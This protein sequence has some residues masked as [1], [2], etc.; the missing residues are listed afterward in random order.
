MTKVRAMQ[1]AAFLKLLQEKILEKVHYRSA[2]YTAISKI[3]LAI[4]NQLHEHISDTTLKRIFG[5]IPNKSDF[6]QATLDILCQFIGYRN[7]D[8]FKK[9]ND[10]YAIPHFEPTPNQVIDDT[11]LL[12]ICLKNHNFETVIEY[13][14]QLPAPADKKKNQLTE[15]WEQKVSPI[16]WT[17]FARDKKAFQV[18]TKE[19]AKTPA[20]QL[21]LY[22]SPIHT[23]F[24]PFLEATEKYYT[25][26][27]NP[28]NSSFGLRDYAFSQAMTY[29]KLIHQDKFKQAHRILENLYHKFPFSETTFEQVRDEFPKM[30]YAANYLLYLHQKDSLTSQYF[31]KVFSLVQSYQNSRSFC[32]FLDAIYQ[33]NKE[34][35]FDMIT[36]YL[37]KC[38][39]LF[40]YNELIDLFYQAILFYEKQGSKDI[41]KALLTT[42]EKQIQSWESKV[43]YLT[44]EP[45]T[46]Q[47]FAYIMQKIAIKQEQIVL[48][49]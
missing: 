9:E 3:A 35:T 45:K 11:H 36:D 30:R 43:D 42:F 22:E 28:K 15:I 2:S 5:L 21:Y 25:Q 12:K 24:S 1:D 48:V 23:H 47:Q 20:G 14:N 13:I 19:L 33:V 32:V 29:R 6:R 40:P 34:Y 26:Y 17:H 4:E 31:E 18:L 27:I 49:A 10:F 41:L 38:S 46:Q 37:K 44:L 16:L 39:S 8:S 7:W